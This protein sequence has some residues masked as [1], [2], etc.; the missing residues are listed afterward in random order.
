MKL[1]YGNAKHRILIV[2]GQS[3]KWDGRFVNSRLRGNSAP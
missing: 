1:E 3:D 2:G